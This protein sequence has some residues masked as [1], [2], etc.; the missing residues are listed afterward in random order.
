MSIKKTRPKS[1]RPSK[2]L[3]IRM[4]LDR[5][6]D[7]RMGEMRGPGSLGGSQTPSLPSA[8]HSNAKNKPKQ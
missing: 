5:M 1:S 4:V 7:D 3:T 6:G 2:N 8:G